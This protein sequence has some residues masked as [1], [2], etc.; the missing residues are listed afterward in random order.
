MLKRLVLAVVSVVE[1]ACGNSQEVSKE[2]V[3]DLDDWVI[4]ELDVRADENLEFEEVDVI[5]LQQ[6]ELVSPEE[7]LEEAGEDVFTA[8]EVV[9][10]VP[11]SNE[12][13]EGEIVEPDL[14]DSFEETFTKPSGTVLDPFIVSSFPYVID[15]STEGKAQMVH[16]YDCAPSTP[17][18]GPEV[19]YKVLVPATGTLR[20]EVLESAGVD[21]DIHVLVDFALDGNNVAHGCQARNDKRLDISVKPGEVLV[22]IDTFSSSANAGPFRLAIELIVPDVWQEVQVAPSVKW[23]KK[24]YTSLFG[25]PQ[26]VN[27]M[28][29]D[30]ESKDSTVK[31]WWGGGGCEKTSSMATKAGAVGA[32]NGG[33]YDPSTCTPMGMVKIDGKVFA[34]NSPFME[35][36]ATLGITPEDQAVIASW[37]TY[38]DWSAMLHALGGHPNLV[39]DG[40]IDIWP[41]KDQDLYTGKHPRTAVGITSKGKLLLVTV[42]GRTEA[43]YGM[44]MKELAQYMIWLGANDAVN[45]DGGG[46]TTMFI[47]GM[48]INGIVNHPSDNKQA[49]HFGERSV[50]DGLLVMVQ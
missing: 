34:Y 9:S 27:V 50:P 30:I 7:F 17:E 46:S 11:F 4:G 18:K 42:D 32:I 47:K 20:L 2:P 8:M 12:F 24:V 35:P 49:D 26:T 15:D 21:V 43:G 28:E 13:P 39:T 31:P 48:S 3:H 22:V 14:Q 44:T 45:L 19:A 10:E 37:P 25:G 6:E 29:V 38:K 33:F 5:S 16:Y 40:V 36:Q 1:V 23:R 41:N